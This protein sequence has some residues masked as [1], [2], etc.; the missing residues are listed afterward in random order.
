[1][2]EIRGLPLLARVFVVLAMFASLCLIALMI[3]GSF[4]GMVA[5]IRWL[6]SIL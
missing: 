6:M 1:M 2:N 5:I 4:A 3:V